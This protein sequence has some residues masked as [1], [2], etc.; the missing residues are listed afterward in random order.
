MT[1][2]NNITCEFVPGIGFFAEVCGEEYRSTDGVNWLRSNGNHPGNQMLIALRA[3][4]YEAM[5]KTRDCPKSLDNR[6]TTDTLDPATNAGRRAFLVESLEQMIDTLA[7]ALENG[8]W[9]C[10]RCGKINFCYCEECG[11]VPA[12]TPDCFF[13]TF[14]PLDPATEASVQRGIDQARRG[15]LHRP[16]RRPHRARARD[17]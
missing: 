6:D 15:E 7:S 10:S 3:A 8:E 5:G 13:T 16:H 12:V 11:L 14:N 4:A 17:V 2:T 9:S 1:H